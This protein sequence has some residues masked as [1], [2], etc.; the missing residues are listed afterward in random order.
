M[1]FAGDT[2]VVVICCYD[3]EG[4]P[5]WVL[6]QSS[7]FVVEQEITIAMQEFQGY[8]RTAQISEITG[9]QAG[10]ITLNLNSTTLDLTKDGTMSIDIN[11]Q[12]NE[13]GNWQRTNVPITNFTDPHE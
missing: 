13:G 12:G 10:N 8:A 1:A 11:Y 5:R 3:S 7:G 9:V 6:G 4:Q 2:I